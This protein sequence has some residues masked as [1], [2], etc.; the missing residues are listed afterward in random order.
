MAIIPRDITD[1]MKDKIVKKPS[2]TQ[3]VSLNSQ[4]PVMTVT[5]VKGMLRTDTMMSAAARFRMYKLVIV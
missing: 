1:V 5:T 3:A 2:A 4:C